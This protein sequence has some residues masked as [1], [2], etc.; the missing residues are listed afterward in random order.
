MSQFAT[1]SKIGGKI[2][3]DTFKEATDRIIFPRR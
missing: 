2:T 1:L 3:T